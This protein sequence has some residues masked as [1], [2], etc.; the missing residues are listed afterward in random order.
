MEIKIN[1]LQDARTFGDARRK[2]HIDVNGRSTKFWA[3]VTIEERELRGY[4]NTTDPNRGRWF[5]NHKTHR[6]ISS[7]KIIAAIRE[8]LD[9][10]LAKN[11]PAFPMH[12]GG[13]LDE[14]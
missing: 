2:K 12:R 9:N 3:S 1:K 8:C 5:I 10:E 11:Q 14:D 6:G 7:P 4:F 13:M